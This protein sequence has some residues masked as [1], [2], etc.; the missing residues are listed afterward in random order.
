MATSIGIDRTIRDYSK[1]YM[2]S[3][4]RKVKIKKGDAVVEETIY[5]Y[6]RYSAPSTLGYLMAIET[7]MPTYRREID[8]A[9]K[10]ERILRE[11]ED[12]MPKE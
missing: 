6:G 8:T 5:P 11:Y 2:A 3:Q 9:R 7:S 12:K 1:A 10:L 4:S